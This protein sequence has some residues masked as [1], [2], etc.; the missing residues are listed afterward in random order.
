MLFNQLLQ[1]IVLFVYLL[2]SSAPAGAEQTPLKIGVIVPLSGP[3]AEFGYAIKN[4]IELAQ[5]K[6]PAQQSGVS[7]I[8]EDSQYRPQIT[9]SAYRYLR[10]THGVRVVFVFGSSALAPIA[11]AE[12]VALIAPDTEPIIAEGRKFVVRFIGRPEHFGRVVTEHLAGRGFKRIGVVLTENK[13]LRSMVEGLQDSL[14][15][16]QKLTVVATVSPEE[17]DFRTAVS[18]L[19]QGEY[20]AVGVLLLSGQIALMYRQMEHQKVSVPTFGSDCFESAS[21]IQ[22][23]SGLMQGA[24]FANTAVSEAFRTEYL[25]RYKNDLQINYA[26][27]ARDFAALVAE[28]IVG[29]DREGSSSDILAKLVA[30]EPFLGVTGRFSFQETDSGDRYFEFPVELRQVAGLQA[31]TY[32]ATA[33]ARRVP[34]ADGA[35]RARLKLSDGINVLVTP[36]QDL[37]SNLNKP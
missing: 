5:Q 16:E 32:R 9:L 22:S 11:E 10:N 21:E 25:A 26:G 24:V 34:A 8:F 37:A 31:R 14:Q 28:R 33:I 4:G 19:R 7:Y 15:P 23:A 1:S 13:Y 6:M 30:P 3:L 29:R 35:D 27:L 20:D 2:L 36:H 17:T 12:R 18:R